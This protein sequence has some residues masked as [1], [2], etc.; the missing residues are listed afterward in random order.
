MQISA[1]PG[2][3]L[4]S[5]CCGAF[6]LHPRVQFQPQIQFAFGLSGAILRTGGAGFAHPLSL[7]SSP[8]GQTR[9]RSPLGEEAGL[10]KAGLRAPWGHFPG[11]AC[12]CQNICAP[13]PFL[14]APHVRSALHPAAGRA[15]PFSLH[16]R[17]P[18]RRFQPGASSS[19]HGGVSSGGARCPRGAGTQLGSAVG[20]ATKPPRRS[21]LSCNRGSGEADGCV[22]TPSTIPKGGVHIPERAG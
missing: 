19:R 14:L 17:A 7:N 20:W 9:S 15:R 10:H 11:S 21:G 16:P 18:P 13:N 8:R 4:A 3:L 6:F 5:Q 12:P 1:P 2:R 22:F